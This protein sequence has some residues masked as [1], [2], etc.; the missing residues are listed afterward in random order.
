MVA[1]GLYLA[2]ELGLDRNIALD[3]DLAVKLLKEKKELKRIEDLQLAKGNPILQKQL[4][5]PAFAALAYD[6]IP[7]L[8]ASENLW[9]M[10]TSIPED[11]FQGIRKGVLS[12]ELG[13]IGNR[14]RRNQVP[15]ISV[16]DGFDLDYKPT[17][18][19]LEDY[20]R[21]K[22][23]NQILAN[24]DADGVG[25]IE[26][27]SYFVGQYGSSIPEA[28]LTGLATW[29]T[30]TLVGT[31][32]GAISPDPFTTAGGAFI[33]NFVGLFTGWN[34]FANK[35]TYDTFKIE[36][37]H[38]W[39][40]LRENGASL[41]DARIRSNAVGTVNAAIEKIGFGFVGPTYLRSL[42]GAKSIVARSGL[43]KTPFMK[44]IQKRIGR[45]FVKNALGK[46][47]KQLTYNAIGRQFARD[48]GIL[49]G[50][51]TG[52]ELLQEVV[53]ITAN[54]LYADEGVTT[55][56]PEQIGDRIWS[57]MTET[58]KGMILFGLVGPGIGLNSNR[59]KANKAKNNT[60]TLEKL[61][62]VS[63]DDLTKK[64]NVNEYEGYAQQAGNKAGVSDFYFNA[65]VFQ[66][67]LDDNAITDEQLELFS[68]ELAKELKNSREEGTVGKLV[69]I[70]SG[71]YLA[72]VANTELGN[73]LFPHVKIG[74][75]EMSQTE[76]T[77]F[78]KDQPELVA[79]YKDLFNEKKQD[80]EQSL[81]ESRSIKRQIKARLIE[82][83]Y[84]KNQADVLAQL[85]QNFA[86]TYAKVLGIKP[87]EFL[88]RFQYNIQGEQDIRSFGKQFFKSR[89]HN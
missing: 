4:T 49:L 82:L 12:R 62:N 56:T 36:G 44:S 87:L 38:S 89:R 77:Q 68:P 30:K 63:K 75:N 20:E 81:K 15:F 28:A 66:Q 2:N 50:T 79:A 26:A 35:L 58:F 34:A 85:P 61:I 25:L 21:I 51:E 8:V 37:G 45:E 43:L 39:L 78:F 54:N 14:L 67:A 16:K 5:D 11:A 40:E 22:E 32:I 47:G 33:G 24:Y 73:S 76:M 18:Q 42:S 29:K 17:E 31:A 84:E 88:N 86:A 70:P 71:T 83:G 27:G 57:T 60:A 19:D 3:S 48:Y 7:N 6:N 74:E 69:K 80:F 53:A 10:F 64:R 46:N 41:E 52:Q 65:D 72:K 59:I 1:E 9:Q 13:M 55:Y 23:I